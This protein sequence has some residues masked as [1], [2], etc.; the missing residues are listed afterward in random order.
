MKK[1]ENSNAKNGKSRKATDC[2]SKSTKDC[3]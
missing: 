2:G 1:T 3:K